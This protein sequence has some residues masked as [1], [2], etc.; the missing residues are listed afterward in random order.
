MPELPEVETVCRG[1]KEIV[2]PKKN[3]IKKIETGAKSLREPFRVK[4]L[5]QSH[6]QK[7]LNIKRKAKYLLFELED[8]YLLSHLGMTGSWR[9]EDQRDNHDHVRIFLQDGRIL[10]YR[11]PRRFGQFDIISKDTVDDD[12]RFV[13]LGPDPVIDD[14]FTGE[15]LFD[16]CKRRQTA[17]KTLIMNQEIVVGVG[18]IYASESLYLAGI[19]PQK[20][21]NKMTKKQCDLLVDAIKETLHEAIFC[22]GST[23]SDFRQA[24]G[25]EGCFQNLFFVYGR[26]KEECLYCS[27]AIRSEFITGRNSYWCPSCQK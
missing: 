21:S 3:S 19:K 26:D 4:E 8:S 1:L 12:R 13:H 18:N 24:G 7:I 10:T 2:E 22:G 11:D 20:K 5:K 6:G 16:Q 9:I 25:S 27:T 14:S 15:Y 17:I 23:I